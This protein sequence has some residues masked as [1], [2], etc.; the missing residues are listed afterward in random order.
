MLA[1]Y[2][3]GFGVFNPSRYGDGAT[4]RRT[5]DAC[6]E[7]E[8]NGDHA[9]GQA[10]D[11]AGPTPFAFDD[12]RSPFNGTQRDLYLRDTTLENAGGPQLWWTDPYG[13]NAS[14]TPFPGGVCQLIGAARHPVARRVRSRSSGAATASTRRACTAQTKNG[15]LMTAKLTRVNVC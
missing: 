5:L 2:D 13:A 7:T 1:S 11:S 4:A 15:A 8:A 12:V 6:W 3:T 9:N 14:P 10:C